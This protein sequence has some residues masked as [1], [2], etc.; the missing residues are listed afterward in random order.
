MES[1]WTPDARRLVHELNT[2]TRSINKKPPLSEG[3]IVASVMQFEEIRYLMKRIDEHIAT[4][5]SKEYGNV[6]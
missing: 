3:A 6:N 4:I 5:E 1:K 2:L